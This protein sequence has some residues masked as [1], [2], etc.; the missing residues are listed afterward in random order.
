MK[1]T[2]CLL[3]SAGLLALLC[4]CRNTQTQVS[5]QPVA[6]ISQSA[7]AANRYFGEV[8][9]SQ[10][11]EMTKDAGKTVK[12]RFVSVG[13]SVQKDEKLFSYDVD[14]AKIAAE[15][16]KL[17]I[18]KMENEQKEFKNQLQALEK[19]AKNAS[20]TEKNRLL[21]EISTLKNDLLE[22]EYRLKAKQ[23]EQEALEESLKTEEVLSPVDGVVQ[24][25][26][27]TEEGPYLVIQQTGDFRIRG[28]INELNLGGEIAEGAA[29]RVI[30]RRDPDQIWNGTVKSVG[31][32]PKEA[33]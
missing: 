16:Q 17:E 8:V 19:Q 29:V 31:K 18:E 27:D 21:L 14:A 7:Q 23:K 20:G 10:T 13:Q 26:S 25:I 32:D 1:K 11:V 33:P 3:L 15:K 12:E 4:G 30:S 9:S 24:K 5:V 6:Q 2:S 22:S 28:T